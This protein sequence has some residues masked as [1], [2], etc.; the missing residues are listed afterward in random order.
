[1]KVNGF[2]ELDKDKLVTMCR[3]IISAIEIRQRKMKRKCLDK[4]KQKAKEREFFGIPCAQLIN[5]KEAE[6]RYRETHRIFGPKWEH[7]SGGTIP[8]CREYISSS[9]YADKCI[10]VK[11]SFFYTYEYWCGKQSED[12]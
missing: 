2:V 4:E 10:L 5:D 9:N 1:M 7:M 3:K 6:R 12:K 8:L 11:T